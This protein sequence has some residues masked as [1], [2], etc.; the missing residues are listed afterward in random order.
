MTTTCVI[1]AGGKGERFWPKSR[2]NLPKQFLN[3]SGNKSMIQQ[4]IDRLQI[5]IPIEQIFVITN[6]LY[7]E[8]IKAQI[9]TLPVENI[10]IEPV[11]RN[12]APCVGLA[13][14]IIE[15]KYP[16]SSMVVLPSDHIIKDENEFI[17]ILKTA[18]S[19]SQL[20]SNL[21]TLGIT[22]T[23]AETGYG[24][25]EST[26]DTIEINN[27]QVFKVNQ[28]VEKPDL[29]K[30]TSYLNSGNYYWNSGI[31]VWRTAV[32][33]SYIKSLM[34]QMHDLL[35]TMK[36]S[37][38]TMDRNSV[39]RAEFPKMPDQSIDYGIMEKATDIY[40]IPCVFGWDDVGSWTALE[41]INNL[42]DCGN[43]IRGNTLNIDTKGCIIESNGKLIATLGVEDLIIVETDDVTLIC[44]KEKAQEIKSLIK[45]LKVQKLE[46]YL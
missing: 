13:S 8:L 12:T 23:Y 20:G 7:A 6:E 31:F 37:F 38:Q 42:D 4:C 22:P 21:V 15:E 44:K 36:V 18:V 46:Q 24:Y 33:R 41:R 45:E 2:T 5:L 30:A 11:G 26:N 27:L 32:I 17:E 16:N 40:V 34:P 14:I 28:F 43:V 29:D 3:I 19:V 25:I 10:I 1:M 35:E 9:P 39:I